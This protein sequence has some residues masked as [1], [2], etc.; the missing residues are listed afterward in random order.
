MMDYNIF[1]DTLQEESNLSWISYKILDH[2]YKIHPEFLNYIDVSYENNIIERQKEFF[3][4]VDKGGSFFFEIRSKILTG[5]KRKDNGLGI[6][7][8]DFYSFRE[9]EKIDEKALK[10]ILD[11]SEKFYDLL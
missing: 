8:Q 1:I 2:L 10:L 5:F 11:H 6:F 4:R 7:I 3:I 9:P